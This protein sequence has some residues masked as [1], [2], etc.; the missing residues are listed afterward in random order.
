MCVYFCVRIV[1]VVLCG[2]RCVFVCVWFVLFRSSAHVGYIGVKFKIISIDTFAMRVLY[3]TNT[4]PQYLFTNGWLRKVP[5]PQKNIENHS[6]SS[7]IATQYL[8]LLPLFKYTRGWRLRMSN[9][10]RRTHTRVVVVALMHLP[11][12]V[13]AA[14]YIESV[15]AFRQ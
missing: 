5:A 6:Y 14:E 15:R 3:A 9:S 12:E 1:L 13:R 2:V 8:C 10:D 4:V 7:L 11:H